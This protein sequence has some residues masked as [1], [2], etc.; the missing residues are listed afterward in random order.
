MATDGLAF[1]QWAVNENVALSSSIEQI[2]DSR[3]GIDGEDYVHSLLISTPNR[4]PLLP[5]LGGLPFTLHKRID[6][7]LQGFG[8]AGIDPIF[9]FNGLDLACR[10]RAS[11][12]R[13]SRKAANILGDAWST[14]D[15]AKGE[16]AVNMFGRA[17]KFL[18]PRSLS[19]FSS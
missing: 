10:D 9:V 17:C 1:K 19:I 15:N 7:D 12:L 14:Y 2:R 5:A 4:E 6:E 18:K 16:E 13:E 8:E 3:L 11:V